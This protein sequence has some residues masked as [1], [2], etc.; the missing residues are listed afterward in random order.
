MSEKI[1]IQAGGQ[2]CRTQFS[3]NGS[4]SPNTQGEYEVA[5][6]PSSRTNL[7][8]VLHWQD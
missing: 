2:M 7:H 4:G 6:C 5:I 8:S 1:V 3:R